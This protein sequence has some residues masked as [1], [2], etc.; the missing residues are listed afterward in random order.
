MKKDQGVYIIPMAYPRSLASLE[1]MWYSHFLKWT[2]ISR[3]GFV[4]AGHAALSIVDAKTGEV[5]FADFG[6]YISPYGYGRMR[7]KFT[8]PE[9]EIDIKA[10]FDTK[11]EL[12]N[13]PEILRYLHEHPEKTHGT[14]SLFASLIYIEDRDRVFE[15]LNDWKE[16]GI[17]PY[18]PF[19][20]SNSNCSRFVCS[21]I[22]DTLSKDHSQFANFKRSYRLTPST[23][24]NVIA[25]ST[26]GIYYEYSD[27]G[28][29]EHLTKDFKDPVTRWAF[30]PPDDAPL[31]PNYRQPII[32][33]GPKDHQWLGGTDLEHGLESVS[34]AKI[35]DKLKWLE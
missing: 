21:F 30:T 25:G 34:T 33:H 31:R 29:K 9:V 19:K 20:R 26:N 1:G 14:Y 11:G 8:D 23:M 22:K 6:R 32:V 16:K 13:F 24:S 28:L 17:T 2:R 12:M 15:L 5:Y 7:S 27:S 4:R 10:K 18:G 35:F 3:N